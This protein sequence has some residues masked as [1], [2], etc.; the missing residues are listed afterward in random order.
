MKNLKRQIKTRKIIA[1]LFFAFTLIA[2][3]RIVILKFPGPPVTHN[4]SAVYSAYSAGYAA[5]SIAGF[6]GAPFVFAFIGW[7]FYKSGKKK[8]I[9]AE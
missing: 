6:Y 2:I 8:M 1:Y 9:E 7:L 3:I 4:S 5:G